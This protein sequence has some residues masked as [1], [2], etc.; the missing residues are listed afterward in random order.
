MSDKLKVADEISIK[1]LA[2]EL[3]RPYAAVMKAVHAIGIDTPRGPNPRLISAAERKKIEAEL[4][5]AK[6]AKK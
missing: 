6:K 4:G 1:E 5:V 3:G 2:V